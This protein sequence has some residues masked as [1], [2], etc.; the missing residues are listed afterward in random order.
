MFR[1]ALDR[2]VAIG[3]GVVY[4][5]IFERFEPYQSLQQEVLKLVESS[6]PDS[7]NR[8]DIRIL[9]L[10]CGP[11]NFALKLAEAGFTVVGLDRYASLIDLAR[12][13]R[14]A[15]RLA[16]LAF[17]HADIA[18]GTTF[19]D[20]SFDQ[21]VNIHSLYVHPAPDRKLR[22]A[23]RVLKPAGHAVFVNHTRRVELRATF[24][25]LR[26]REGL[27]A[28]FRSLLWVVPNAIF[29]SAR[30][31]VGPTYW[32][33]DEFRARLEAAGFTVLEA[34]RTFLNGASLLVWARKDSVE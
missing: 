31:Q 14:Q 33:E 32:K 5:Y 3:Y 15:K 8:R 26:A 6:V 12:E 9:E 18:A 16:N 23:C 20:A 4:D 10:G 2:M 24:G 19:R 29:E 28:A 34:R 17:Q 30:K 22:E 13:K 21:V 25:E 1:R 11:G 27:G 7:A